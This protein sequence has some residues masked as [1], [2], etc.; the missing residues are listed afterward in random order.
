M[1]QILSSVTRD[2]T[3]SLIE[4]PVPIELPKLAHFMDYLRAALMNSG[5]TGTRAGFDKE[6]RF[7]QIA[8]C[9]LPVPGQPDAAI[10]WLITINPDGTLAP[11]TAIAT[12]S[13]SPGWERA[14]ERV[15]LTCVTAALN[16]KK[17]RYFFRHTFGHL[18]WSL[19][20][21]YYISDFR[22]AP[23]FTDA[24][25]LLEKIAFI[26][27]YVEAV[28][29]LQAHDLSRI[30]ANQTA[31]LL[32]V[33]LDTGFYTLSGA[34][35][36][37]VI[38]DHETARC[39]QRGYIHPKPHPSEM[40]KKGTECALGTPRAVDRDLLQQPFVDERVLQCPADIRRLFRAVAKLSPEK[41]EAFFGA[42]GLYQISLTLGRHHPSIQMAYQVAAVDALVSGRNNTAQAY[43]E[44]V[45]EHCPVEF[46]IK[47]LK[48]IY[49]DI[50][51]AHFHAG[52]FPG[53]ETTP[54]IALL[55]A[56]GKRLK[57]DDLKDQIHAITQAVLIRW[58]L[59]Q[60]ASDRSTGDISMA[61]LYSL[62]DLG[63]PRFS[64][65]GEGRIIFDGG[66]HY[67]VTFDAR[68]M[69]RGTLIVD[70]VLPESHPLAFFIM[71][72]LV[73]LRGNTGDF[74]IDI[75]NPT[76]VF[77]WDDDDPSH[78]RFGP[79][80]FRLSSRTN[81]DDRRGDV[82]ATLVNFAFAED[83]EDLSP[84]SFRFKGRDITIS[85]NDAY[86]QRFL[87]VY[88]MGG[89]V[90]T[91]IVTIHRGGD[92]QPS[93]IEDLLLELTYP[94]SLATSNKVMFT[95]YVVTNGSNQEVYRLHAE[96]ITRPFSR[97][98]ADLR[99][100]VSWLDLINA[101]DAGQLNQHVP[102]TEL[103]KRID[104][105]TD[106][107][108]LDSFMDTRTLLACTVIDAITNEFA[109]NDTSKVWLSNK[110]KPREGS[111]RER[112]VH[113]LNTLNVS[114]TFTQD[115]TNTRNKLAHEGRF[116]NAPSDSRTYLKESSECRWVAFAVL[117]RLVAPNVQLKSVYNPF[118]R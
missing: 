86:R 8:E 92:L 50:R 103:R 39:L 55:I 57:R 90:E 73:S 116:R 45:R 43:A 84:V 35:F 98:G 16:E 100:T 74:E 19:D 78:M 113:V 80:F 46:P 1:E 4:I 96:A 30:K 63:E 114:C 66:F 29:P 14:A 21:A 33:F 87:R 106:S 79:Q 9:S 13:T 94:L 44:L 104:Q 38:E 59:Y 97:S 37:W 58:L 56:D 110:G 88:E 75:T 7:I 17:E 40:P 11:L 108:A 109:K 81:Q 25:Y 48:G 53:G 95:H 20:G 60:G 112:L 24:D 42:A 107:C 83:A 118:A 93:E 101:W 28:D 91:A 72:P 51:S 10:V 85:P 36:Q 115:V 102:I 6:D 32:S 76:G 69:Q 70:C 18:G 65:T 2:G 34:L 61:H 15:I 77:S 49:G 5:L 26:D 54:D 68:Q 105:Y 52:S 71:P 89:F 62:D 23:A 41:R 22:L 111:F 82:V 27:H 64:Y 67:P 117:S 3:V 31:S 99:L 47:E 12:N